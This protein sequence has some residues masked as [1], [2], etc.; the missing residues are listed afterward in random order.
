MVGAGQYIGTG[1]SKVIRLMKVMRP[2]RLLMRSAGLKQIVEALFASLKPMAYAT[3]FLLIVCLMFSVTGMAFFR[4]KFHACT[5]MALDGTLGEGKVECAGGFFDRETE[6]FAP[7][8][9]I[10]PNWGS[11]FDSLASSVAVLFK[12]LTL[13]WSTFYWYAQ[14]VVAVD[15]QPVKGAAMTQASLYFHIF[16]LVGSFFSLNL[17]ASFMC[18]TFYSLQ[19]TAQLEEVQWMAIQQ[20]LKKNQPTKNRVPPRNLLS[21]FLRQILSSSLWQ[22]FSAFCLLL[23]VTFMGS[24]HSSQDAEFDVFL[25][26]QNTIFFGIMCAEAGLHLVSVGPSLYVLDSQHQFD[27]LLIA[28]TSATIVFAETLRQLSQVTRILRLFKFL[29]ALAKDKTISNVFE[30]VS[31]SMGQ[32]VNIIIVLAVLIV[33]LSVLAV[34]LFGNVRFGQRLGSSSSPPLVFDIILIA[35][36]T[37]NSSL[38]PLIEGLCAQIHVNLR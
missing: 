14:D 34:Q 15:V 29:R 23:N 21:T 2:I 28:A 18:D 35:F 36:I 38:E 31:V 11:H 17:F 19:G 5:H 22:N 32:V 33:M 10:A 13:S 25:D 6:L 30:T 9:W 8:A 3:L 12:C 20:M 16:L 27:I 24:A 4:N 1:A 37:G 26:M 7:R